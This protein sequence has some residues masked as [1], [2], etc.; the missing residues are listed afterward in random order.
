M[1]TRTAVTTGLVAAAALSV[2]GCS[3]DIF[4]VSVEL[5]V[6]A[7]HLDFGT[8]AGTVPAVACDAASPQSCGTSSVITLGNGAGETELGAGCDGGTSRCYVQANTRV[9]YVV[10]VLR[11]EAFTSKVGRKAV[12]LVRMLDVAYT[13]PS[14]SA[15]FDVPQI[16]VYVGPAEA[17]QSGDAGVT[18][19]DSVPLIAA[20]ETITS[21]KPGHLTIADGSPG[22]ALIES[23]IKRKVPFVFIV[24]TTPRLESGAPLP[25]G[26]MDIV[27]RPLLGLGVR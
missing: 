1:T 23:S 20:R 26:S 17:R 6:E 21:D 19:V 3:S 4:D 25:S 15:T 9:F 14:N 11:D 24:T 10:D 27:L 8:M 2:A 16:D 18:M 12:T 22:R 13:V 7:F 5:G